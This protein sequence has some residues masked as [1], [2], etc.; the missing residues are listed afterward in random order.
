MHFRFPLILSFALLI[1]APGFAR[2]EYSVSDTYNDL[3]GTSLTN[4][5]LTSQM[6]DPSSSWTL[7]DIETLQVMVMDTSNTA[8]VLLK[9]IGGSTF[10]LFDTGSWTSPTRGYAVGAQFDLAADFNITASDTFQ[11]FVGNKL[12]ASPSA[13]M[14]L[15]PDAFAGEFLIGYNDNGTWSAGDG[16]M[17]EPLLYATTTATPI[18]GAAW[19][20]GSGLIGLVGLRRKFI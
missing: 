20:L 8:D 18:P 14:W 17:N 10:T 9:V 5:Q 3:W 4:S 12:I 11:L 1:A 19:L 15:A 7:K 16:D 2:A 13:K 6:A